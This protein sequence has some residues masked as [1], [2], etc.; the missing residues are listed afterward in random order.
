MPR[1]HSHGSETTYWLACSL[2]K[3]A[4]GIDTGSL[5]P[6]EKQAAATSCGAEYACVGA[7]PQKPR[8]RAYS[9]VPAR[10]A[11]EK[12]YEATQCPDSW[13]HE[14][15][16]CVAPWLYAGGCTLRL[17]QFASRESKMQVEERCAVSWPCKAASL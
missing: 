6:A 11:C 12:D 2:M 3:H 7:A 17:P 13:L 4:A 1:R 9:E 14:G 10:A 5:T 15:V 8:K 16:D